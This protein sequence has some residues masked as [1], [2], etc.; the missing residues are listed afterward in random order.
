MTTEDEIVKIKHTC[1]GSDIVFVEPMQ[2]IFNLVGYIPTLIGKG[3][4]EWELSYSKTIKYKIPNPN[5]E[6]IYG[7]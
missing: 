3:V 6:T 4:D 7:K 1:Y 5:I 2:L